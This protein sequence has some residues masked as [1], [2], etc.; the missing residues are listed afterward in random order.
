MTVFFDC[1]FIRPGHMDGITRYSEEL[2]SALSRIRPIT[3]LVANQEQLEQL[4]EGS[5]FLLVNEP[6]SIRELTLAGRLNRF[7]CHGP[8]ELFGGCTT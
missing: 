8:C 7:S 3:A 6:T 4:P 1:R 5:N 2:F